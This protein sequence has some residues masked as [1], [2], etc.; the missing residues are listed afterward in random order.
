MKPNPKFQDMP[1]SFWATV[2][3]VSQTCGYAK[4]GADR[5]KAL[6]DKEIEKGFKKLGLNADSL[7]KKVKGEPLVDQLV[8]YFAYRAKILNEEVMP[9][10]M[11]AGEAKALYEKTK[12]RLK[13]KCPLPMNKQ[14]KEKKGPAYLTCLVNMLVEATVKGQPVEYDPKQLTT[15]T[16]DG[17]PLRT[18]SRR[19]DGAFPSPIN[20]IAIWEI[21]EY[22]YTTTFGS[23][24]ADGVYETLLDGMEIEEMA[25]S[26]GIQVLHYLILDAKFTWWDKGKSYLCRIVDMVNMGYVDEVIV[27]KEVVTRIPALARDWMNSLS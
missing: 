1:L 26:E 15:V 18:M 19:V 11:N 2:K 7:K 24:V 23:R 13:P 3:S 6:S 20:P 10:L 5:V 8:A 25:E 4:R 21:K 27:G 22:Y 12:K 9:L 17:V 14:K 16:K